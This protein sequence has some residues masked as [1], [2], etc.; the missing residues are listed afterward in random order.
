MFGTHE[1]FDA[2]TLDRLYPHRGGYLAKV[3]LADVA[4]VR[5]GYLLPADA[6]QNLTT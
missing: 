4:N 3:V 1:P 5:A 6:W 2:A